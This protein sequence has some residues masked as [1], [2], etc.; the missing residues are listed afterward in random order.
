MQRTEVGVG[1]RS[2]ESEDAGICSAKSYE[3]RP[4]SFG[5]GLKA[6]RGLSLAHLTF[7]A[8][9]YLAGWLDD[10]FKLIRALRSFE[11]G[12]SRSWPQLK[13]D[14]STACQDCYPVL[15][16]LRP[17]PGGY[18]KSSMPSLVSG[19]RRLESARPGGGGSISTRPNGVWV[20]RTAEGT[21]ANP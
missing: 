16:W 14:L 21:I 15:P 4:C 19:W 13:D 17:V 10:E 1:T 8:A 9:L 5:L 7:A 6:Q 11:P 18:N 12:N 20:V 3:N 2:E